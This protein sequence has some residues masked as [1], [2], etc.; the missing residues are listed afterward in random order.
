MITTVVCCICVMCTAVLATYGMTTPQQNYEDA[1]TVQDE[2]CIPFFLFF[3]SSSIL[4]CAAYYVT[5]RVSIAAMQALMFDGKVKTSSFQ[6]GRVKFECVATYSCHIH[7][8]TQGSWEEIVV[9]EEGD[10]ADDRQHMVSSAISRRAKNKNNKHM[11]N[12]GAGQQAA[13][14]ARTLE[15]TVEESVSPWS[16]S[17]SDEEH[18]NNNVAA[19][20]TKSMQEN[21]KE[22][23]R[24]ST[25]TDEENALA[26]A[27]VERDN[28][29]DESRSSSCCSS[30][31]S[32]TEVDIVLQPPHAAKKTERFTFLKVWT[33]VYGLAVGMFCIVYSLLLPN[34]LSG[35]TFCSC[36][37][38]VGV[39]ECVQMS[40]MMNGGNIRSCFSTTGRR[41]IERKRRVLR[42]IASMRLQQGGG[43]NINK[44]E[45]EIKA[46]SS[47]A[48]V[49][50]CLCSLLLL[51]IVC[52][53]AGGIVS[54]RL[55][56]NAGTSS[57]IAETMD[58][59]PALASILI[60]AVGVACIR[61]MRKTEDIRNTMELS[62][63]M[64]SM[65]SLLCMLCIVLLSGYNASSSQQQ[66]SCVWDVFWEQVGT[67]QRQ[68]FFG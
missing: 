23:R 4:I 57:N 3:A 37:W 64:C 42:E 1:K 21:D 53:T 25:N 26:S 27:A 40:G 66:L 58:A 43:G 47:S 65:G 2:A 54:G 49:L 48:P 38:M 12:R 14:A 34:E 5:V 44:E 33:N 19:A 31:S 52:K 7:T 51:G 39:Y 59:W 13:A 63:P 41:G 68:V 22:A 16:F 8:R 20:A 61:N 29:D 17:D 9:G 56:G 11:N 60:P 36:L 55:F 46:G 45:V 6:F 67:E 62:M 28:A 15:K 24:S 18:K 10:G 50:T 30:S 32:C 35:F